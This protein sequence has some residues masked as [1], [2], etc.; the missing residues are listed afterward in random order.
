MSKTGGISEFCR[1]GLNTQRVTSR[2]VSCHWAGGDSQEDESPR[3]GDSG[4][5]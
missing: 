3:Q 4:V 5:C 2:E 1:T